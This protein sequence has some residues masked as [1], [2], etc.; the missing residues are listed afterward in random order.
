MHC[1]ILIIS[2][3]VALLSLSSAQGEQRSRGPSPSPS[4]I[5]PEQLLERGREAYNQQRFGEALEFF[6]A[7]THR[8][9]READGYRRLGTSA[10]MA[11]RFRRAAIAYGHYLRLAPRGR[12]RDAVRSQLS[13]VRAQLSDQ[14][15]LQQL[16]REWSR[17]L[18]VV[19]EA[20]N[21]GPVEGREGSLARYQGLVEQGL[22]SPK[23][24]EL[25]QALTAKVVA[26][27]EALLDASWAPE[28]QA[29]EGALRTQLQSIALWL[30]V[31][32]YQTDEGARLTILQRQL[33]ALL[34]VQRRDESALQRLAAA[35]EHPAIR[36]A[37]LTTQIERGA[38]DDAR[39]LG[40][41]LLRGEGPL[42]QSGRLR[43]L[44]G[45]LELRR[46]PESAEGVRRLRE[47]LLE[48]DR[49]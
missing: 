6:T 8:K 23:F 9:P 45:L 32:H 14:R 30:R 49:W 43:T 2:C 41:N 20:I 37:L 36:I 31:G 42:S 33:D 40:E 44:L 46:T 17:K 3:A 38:L 10:Q 19:G 12:H 24:E 29:T 11:Q 39:V 7:L 47:G 16:R 35:G 5:T 1:R 34:A 15:P 13:A 27:A 25:Q 22:F 48:A 4:A 28:S 18:R 21:T 26:A